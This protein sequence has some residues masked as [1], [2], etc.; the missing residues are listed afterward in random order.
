MIQ[1]APGLHATEP[2]DLG[3]G[4][5]PLT[6]RS[7]LI[8][9]PGGNLSVYGAGPLW[10]EREAIRDLGGISRQYLNHAHEASAESGLVDHEFNAP[11]TVHRDDAADVSASSPVGDVFASRHFDDDDFEVIPI[12]GHTAGATAYLWRGPEAR[13]L[14]TGDSVF[15]R[16]GEWGAALLDGVSERSGYVASLE[17]LAG[18]DFDLLAAGVAPV[19][20]PFT[21]ATGP[22]DSGERLRAIA[23]RLRAGGDR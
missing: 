20:Q 2:V 14:F 8:E 23:A 9:R 12:P 16:D 1:I 7:Y 22:G 5:P 21:V 17:L 10:A 15:V 19:G 3:F 18:L 4:R 11:L 13:V 6:A